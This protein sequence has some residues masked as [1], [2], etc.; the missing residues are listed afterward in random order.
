A[1]DRDRDRL[2]GLLEL[3]AV[4]PQRL[5]EGISGRVLASGRSILI[6]A[7]ESSQLAA[8]VEEHVRSAVA[9]R[10]IRSVVAVPL[11]ARGTTL[12]VA[13]LCRFTAE[14]PYTAD[15]QRLVEDIAA[16]ASLAISNSR[17]LVSLKSELAERRRAEDALTRT[18]EQLRQAQKMEAIG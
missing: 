4:Q 18:E 1:W 13:N 8:S 3:M 17:L 2:A 11:R 12:G 10:N 5:G 9:Q 15:D 7:I 16:H 6:P 14:L